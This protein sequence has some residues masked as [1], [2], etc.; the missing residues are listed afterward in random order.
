[1]KKTV[2]Q[3]AK[4]LMINFKV[5][6][7]SKCR[8]FRK[9]PFY[10]GLSSKDSKS[11]Q[12][13]EKSGLD[14]LSFPC[15][16]LGQWHINNQAVI[17]NLDT[18]QED[19]W[20][21]QSESNQW[22][23]IVGF[24]KKFRKFRRL[25][26]IIIS[27]NFPEFVI[28]PESVL[29]GRVKEL[30]KLIKILYK[31]FKYNIPLYFVF[32]EINT[33]AGFNEFFADL[34]AEQ[35]NQILGIQ[36]PILQ[37]P[38][39]YFDNEFNQ[40]LNNINLHLFARLEAEREIDR[41]AKITCFP[42]QIML[43]K[44]SLK[45]LIVETNELTVRGMYFVG[46]ATTGKIV[47]F[48]MTAM[49]MRFGLITHES[50][51]S[52]SKQDY[53]SKKILPDLILKDSD[54]IQINSKVQKI[55]NMTRRTCWIIAIAIL[56]I[57]G[58]GFSVSYA[59]NSQSIDAMMQILPQYRQA[60]LALKSSETSLQ[61][62]LKILNLL[63]SMQNLKLYF[64]GYEAFQINDK[65]DNIFQETM[66]TQ[67]MPRVFFQLGNILKHKI[68]NPE[69]L[70]EAL[71]GYLVFS[72]IAA[73]HSEWIKPPIQRYIFTKYHDS[74]GGGFNINQYLNKA[75]KYPVNSLPLNQ[76]LVKKT[77]ESLRK[78]PPALFAYHELKSQS[79]IKQK[80]FSLDQVIKSDF[81]MV[82][83]YKDT[84]QTSIPQLFTLTGYLSLHNKYTIS[85]IFHTADIY[86]ILGLNNFHNTH[87]LVT[88]MNPQVWDY[89]NQ[90]YSDSWYQYLNNIQIEKFH[91]LN[92]AIQVLNLL[93]QPH[94]PLSEILEKILENTA[95]IR[96]HN[97]S[98][99]KMYSRLN[100]F[101]GLPQKP[102][103]QYKIL[104]KNLGTLRDYLSNLST[105][106]HISQ[107]EF[108]DASAYLQNKLPNNP[109][110]I[111]KRQAQ[112]L[113]WPINNW[114]NSIADNSFALLL[115]GSRQVINA[116]WQNT[117]I[118]AYQAN[119]ENRFP[120]S[121]ESDVD[122]NL[123]SF[124][125]FFG[126]NGIFLKFAQI[127]LLPFIDMS[128]PQWACYKMGPYSL[129]I[130]PIV[131]AQLEQANKI[132]IFYFS[133]N[134]TYPSVRFFIRPRILDLQS[135]SIFLQL[136]NQNF[137]YRHG[138]Q[139]IFTWHWPGG[140]DTQ[141]VSVSFNDF[142]GKTSSIMADGPW[143]WFSLLNSTQLQP[144][145]VPGHYIWTIH[146][147]GHQAS[148]DVWAANNQPVFNLDLLQNLKLPVVI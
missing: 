104:I 64:L 9:L 60:Y 135:K 53:F 75:L 22:L 10:L 33:I 102:S 118:P 31:Q 79:E 14:Y 85:L 5:I 11:Q 23:E 24:L 4:N 51:Y 115:Q 47:N 8:I 30:S 139:K 100:A 86:Q 29:S 74:P 122:V 70:Y 19:F 132:R 142:S 109:I 138:P 59:H 72:P 18:K 76:E 84:V 92:Q 103:G 58:F 71:K 146:K 87:E 61:A 44:P 89:Y 88:E 78:I 125:E 143:V 65:L 96:G 16:S 140:E 106:P 127:Y 6:T 137:I 116:A 133:N 17:L 25:N 77:R 110:G 13:F 99:S 83:C 114:I 63:N 131:K 148:F 130:S 128:K 93:T 41:R 34:N 144:T 112:Q 117:V 119:I 35:R 45:Q 49:A 40:L 69:I 15:Q 68:N 101:T 147:N 97:M 56:S 38:L 82:F 124:G 26:G 123:N 55:K 81:N 2:N 52:I 57:A 1:M 3:T 98:I 20:G 28:Q 80:Q 66:S 90:D 105:S 145:G 136:S 7:K 37:Q 54:I 62:P 27:L 39:S 134:N 48:A 36:F 21:I 120:F 126:N 91:D 129:E 108:Q 67:F 107:A 73:S 95:D 113:P 12:F 50:S 121:Q 94:N 42:Q 32:T 111:L 43:C 46:N 141:Q